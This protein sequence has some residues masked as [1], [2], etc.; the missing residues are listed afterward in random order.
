MKDHE[1]TEPSLKRWYLSDQRT[2]LG[3]TKPTERE[4]QGYN[5]GNQLLNRRT[6]SSLFR[7]HGQDESSDSE[8]SAD[9]NDDGGVEYN[10]ASDDE[11]DEDEVSGDGDLDDNAS[12]QNEGEF[13]P[14]IS[15]L[16]DGGRAKACLCFSFLRSFF[17]AIKQLADTFFFFSG[18]L[19][20]EA[21]RRQVK[22][23]NKVR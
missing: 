17:F 1:N 13:P 12:G 19:Q 22:R 5:T 20:T 2:A 9:S 21:R 3:Y 14:P 4:N 23:A 18:R 6:R 7:Y 8:S 11:E 10:S 15:L 16:L